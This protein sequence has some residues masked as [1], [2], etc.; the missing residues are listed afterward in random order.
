MVANSIF[1]AIAAIVIQTL[2]AEST[3]TNFWW[4][5]VGIVAL[6]FFVVSAEKITEAFNDDDVKTY[7]A[8]YLPYNF[9]VLLLFVDL[10]VIVEHHAGNSV[11]ERILAGAVLLAGWLWGWGVDV[12]FLFRENKS[13]FKKYLNEI[14]GISEPTRKLD[15]F[16][17]FFFFLRACT[18]KKDDGGTAPLPHEDVYT[19]LQPS[20][21][22]GVGVFAIRDIKEGT[23][24]F[25]DNEDEIVW[26][27]E[28]EITNLPT[29]IR[30]LYDDFAI[31]KNGKYGCPWNFN[32]L[33]MGWYLNDSESPN[34]AVD[35]EYNMTAAH[36]IMKGE[37]LTID[38]SRFS[39]L[40]Y[41]KKEPD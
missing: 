41:R 5:L 15:W 19:R 32:R 2:A 31:I 34:V 40:P 21:V 38:S 12:A 29:E 30:K 36:D 24:I 25:S 16:A 4:M 17:K 10:F 11:V 27:D 33:T 14:N 20:K 37:E 39:V 35:G 26:I 1:A 28:K 13:G 18:S 6:V 7:V 9:G 3:T 8:Y 23:V 22:D